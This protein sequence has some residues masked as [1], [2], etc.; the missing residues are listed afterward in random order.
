M[1]ISSVIEVK[2]NPNIPEITSGD[3]VRVSTKIV[4]GDKERIQVFQGVILR[5][6]RRGPSSSFTVRRVAY[7]VGVERTFPLHS[8]RVEKV[9]IVRH[10]KKRRAKLY[11]LRGL[12]SRTARLKER[13]LSAKEIE[14]EQERLQKL[15]QEQ[16][17]VVEEQGQEEA[18]P[19]EA[20]ENAP[21][22]ENKSE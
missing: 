15:A 11:Y 7:G 8:P 3:T 1:N 10:G 2:P 19:P 6:R 21:E 12:S 13:R 9:E 4:E 16:D 14:R 5:V 22:L 20:I 18:I 17:L